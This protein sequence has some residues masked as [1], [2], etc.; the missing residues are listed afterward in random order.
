MNLVNE[1][2]GND[3]I[4]VELDKD[5]SKRSTLN[6]EASGHLITIKNLEALIKVLSTLN[7]YE[8]NFRVL[9]L[10]ANQVLPQN[11]DFP[12]IKLDFKYDKKLFEAVRPSYIL[13][14]SIPLNILTSQAI[15]YELKGWE[16]FTGIPATLGG[17]ISMNAGTRL[18]E[19]GNLIQKVKYVDRY[20]K[21]HEK[22]VTKEDFAYRK[23]NFLKNDD[24]IYEAEITHLG[25]SPGI[26]KEI[27]D[28]LAYRNQTQPLNDKT[29]GCM[30][31]N[32]EESGEN[33]SSS[34]PAG[35]FLDIMGLKGFTI[36]GAQVSHVHANFLINKGGA[37]KEDV[38]RLL[39]LVKSELALQFGKEFELEVKL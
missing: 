39:H 22:N 14:A 31:K 26:G 20:G 34:C 35:K 4:Q 27:K 33:N 8:L 13:P 37:T 5:L 32:Y 10:G 18:G 29:C 1:F 23:N 30:F 17:A 19:I 21:L 6:L 24:V 15:K 7:K 3:S 28:Y 25:V 2:E 9:G 12:Y 36:G 16:A 38:Q 11:S